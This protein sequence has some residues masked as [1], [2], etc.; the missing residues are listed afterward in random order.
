MTNAA[1]KRLIRRLV[2]AEAKVA[3]EV[4][5]AI[6]ELAE[7][8]MEEHESAKLLAAYLSDR[9]FEIEYP[10][11]AM[12]TAFRAVATFTLNRSHSSTSERKVLCGVNCF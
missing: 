8:G 11:R 2:A 7:P 4:S 12:P 6:A 1:K 3:A 9:G 10:W 5:D